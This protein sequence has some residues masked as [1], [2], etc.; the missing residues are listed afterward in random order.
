[1][2]FS[3]LWF[4]KY[5]A[6][7]ND[8]VVIDPRNCAVSP[9]ADFIRRLCDRRYGIGSDG[10]LYGPVKDAGGFR[11]RI[12]NPDGSEAEKSGN[13]IRIFARYLRD[14][15]YVKGGDGTIVTTGGHVYFRYLDAIAH[16]IEVDMGTVTFWSH[17]IPVPGP[18]RE[19]I[20]EGLWVGGEI[21]RISCLSVGNP[22]CVVRLDGATESEVRRLGPQIELHA[23][24]PKR[25]NVQFL[26]VV[27]RD[28]IR[29]KIWERGA[30]YT[31]SSGS[32]SCAAAGAARRLGLVDDRVRV[33][34]PG[35]EIDISFEA[36]GRI[37][38]TGE[39]R[40]T[41]C[42]VVTA[43]LAAALRPEPGGAT[44]KVAQEPISAHI[45]QI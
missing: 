28:H 20:D 41:I 21:L 3:G 22:H 36:N 4:R 29:V 26:E 44:A 37:G 32:S 42:G 35:G 34:M 19:I 5:E 25:I 24:F 9:D 40:S 11:V 27:A 2:L 6:L 16:R 17:E 45:Q 33:E 10:L 8:Y 15:G 39:V 31:L 12:F 43:D 7:G 14:A 18:E 30:G 23:M 38:M 1:V 13:G